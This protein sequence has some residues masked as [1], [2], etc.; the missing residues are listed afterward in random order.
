MS[1]LFRLLRLIPEIRRLREESD[2]LRSERDSMRLKVRAASAEMGVLEDQS[3][4]LKSERDRLVQDVARQSTELER[5]AAET[6]LPQGRPW[7]RN[8][9]LW[10]LSATLSRPSVSIPSRLR[11]FRTHRLGSC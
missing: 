8:V 1:Q 9:T 10:W 5:R 6:R 2:E 7:P 3:R 11:R 4:V